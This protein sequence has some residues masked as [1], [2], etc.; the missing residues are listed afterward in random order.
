MYV[1]GVLNNQQLRGD[2]VVETKANLKVVIHE[3]KVSRVPNQ[4]G[5]SLQYIML[6]IH[7]SGREPS[8]CSYILIDREFN[9]F[10]HYHGYKL[11]TLFQKGQYFVATY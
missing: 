9:P 2:M 5:V 10:V 11:Q 6:E 1:D 7:H 8:V 4:N 3:S